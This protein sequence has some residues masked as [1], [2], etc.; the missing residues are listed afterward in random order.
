ME[1]AKTRTRVI[2]NPS[3]GGGSCEPLAVREAL[4]EFDIEWIDT[5]GLGDA[6]RAA[7]EWRG[8]LLIAVGGGGTVNEG[9]NGLGRGRFPGEVMLAVLPLGVRTALVANL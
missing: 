8:G 1:G 3:S 5:R 2:C 4:G 9:G 6:R 7:E